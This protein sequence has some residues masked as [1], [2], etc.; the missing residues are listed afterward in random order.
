MMRSVDMQICPALAKGKNCACRGLFEVSVI[1]HQQRRFAAQFQYR[2]FQMF[3]AGAGDY[4]PHRR[5]TGEID[6]AYGGVG[7]QGLHQRR[8]VGGGQVR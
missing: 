3:T 7:D 6:A 5:R 4:P 2:G 1:Q 8:R